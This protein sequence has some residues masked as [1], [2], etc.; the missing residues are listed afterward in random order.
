MFINL[1]K[2]ADVNCTK[3]DEQI[4][5]RTSQA[6]LTQKPVNI[7]KC[8]FIDLSKLSSLREKVEILN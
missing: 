3:I 4:L 2:S 5:P 6:Q 8:R 7:D 1:P